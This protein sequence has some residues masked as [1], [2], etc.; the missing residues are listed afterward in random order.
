[1]QTFLTWPQPRYYQYEKGLPQL[2]WWLLFNC[3]LLACL[4]IFIFTRISKMFTY[5]PNGGQVLAAEQQLVSAPKPAPSSPSTL[6]LNNYSSLEQ[7]IKAWMASQKTGQWSVVVQDLD[8][9][10]NNV[11]INSDSVYEAASIYKLFLTIPLAQKLPVSAWQNT[12]ISG[13]SQPDV[14]DC[15]KAMI[16]KS[17]NPCGIAVGSYLNWQKV[18]KSL[19][20]VGFSKTK[21]A[22]EMPTTTAGD[23]ASYLEGLAGGKWFDGATRDFILSSLANQK[24]RS[25][26]PGG[27]PGC[28]VLNKTGDIDDVVH[29]AAI[30]TNGNSHYVLVIFSKQG[31]FKQIAS[32]SN[33]INAQLKQ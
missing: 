27:C 32:L 8:K 12:K 30:I 9:P 15:V 24:L 17:D 33:L 4:S 22:L 16:S 6:A 29:D 28:T 5:N 13:G 21:L 20:A 3:T 2:S 25:G 11:A 26:I 10:H 31:S 14:A 1:M 7:S 23:T 18:D 19:K